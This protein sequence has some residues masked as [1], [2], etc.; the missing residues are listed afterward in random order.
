MSF[1]RPRDQKEQRLSWREWRHTTLQFLFLN[2]NPC[3]GLL[4]WNTNSFAVIFVFPSGSCRTRSSTGNC[5]VFPFIYRG[6]RY[7][8]C[9]R[10]RSK[11]P[12]CAITPNYDHDKLYGYCGGRKS[13]KIITV[14]FLFLWSKTRLELILNFF[15]VYP[16][17]RPIRIS[18]SITR[19][20]AIQISFKTLWTIRMVLG[21]AIRWSPKVLRY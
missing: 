19:K 7:N 8:R 12:W 3:T 11:R 6:R 21:S 14:L 17:V 2:L 4:L 15:F 10:V 18:T 5:C 13:K 16:A 1:R 9:T 20:Y